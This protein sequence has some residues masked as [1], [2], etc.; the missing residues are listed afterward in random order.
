M[1]FSPGVPDNFLIDVLGD[2]TRRLRWTPPDDPDLADVIIRYFPTTNGTPPHWDSM[3][4]L[5]RGFLTASPLETVEPAPGAW[6]FVARAISTSGTLSEGD[7]R[8][9]AEIGGQR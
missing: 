6:T 5:H 7:T 4:S 2:G 8:I 3:S 9:N 1:P